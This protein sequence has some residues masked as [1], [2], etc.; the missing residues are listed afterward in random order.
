M[1]QWQYSSVIQ[2]LRNTNAI[3]GVLGVSAGAEIKPEDCHMTSMCSIFYLLHLLYALLFIV[4]WVIEIY[5][6]VFKSYSLLCAQVFMAVLGVLYMVPEIKN[7]WAKHST[8]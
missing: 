8:H 1:L 7:E 4:G 3:I 5:L 6:E 2:W